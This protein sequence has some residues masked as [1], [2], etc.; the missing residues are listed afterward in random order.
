MEYF[1]RSPINGVYEHNRGHLKCVS[2]LAGAFAAAWGGEQEAQIAGAM[3]DIG[4]YGDLFQGL[5]RGDTKHVDHWSA[6]A[7]LALQQYKASALSVALSIQGHHRGLMQSDRYQLQDSLISAT[8]A[9][10]NAS[11]QWAGNSPEVLYNRWR[12]MQIY[13]SPAPSL[14]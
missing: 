9:E 8:I 10:G 11:R 3:H 2:N 12:K 13:L 1:S 14:L 5:L 6:G 4:K 7:Y